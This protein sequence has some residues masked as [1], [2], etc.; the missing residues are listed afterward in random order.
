MWLRHESALRY[1]YR[2]RISISEI[3]SDGGN[4]Q[5][6]TQRL[7]LQRFKAILAIEICRSL[8]QCI[9]DHKLYSHL[10]MHQP[11]AVQSVKQKDDANLLAL[12]PLINR[13]TT[14][15]H[16]RNMPI[17]PCSFSNFGGDIFDPY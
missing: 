3:L 10:L 4:R 7:I 2:Q 6:Q 9:N 16:A 12:I 15:K 1:D 17:I 5:V 14:D 13:Q 11:H 8:V